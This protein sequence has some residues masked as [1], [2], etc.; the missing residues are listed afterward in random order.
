VLLWN[1]ST[2]AVRLRL[3]CPDVAF[4]SFSP[5]GN[6]LA[7]A[8][9]NGTVLTWDLDRTAI[10]WSATL[11]KARQTGLGFSPNGKTLTAGLETGEYH[12]W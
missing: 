8:S 3:R 11:P 2:G 6:L 7:A 4:L 12:V 9:E 10:L 5:N 1:A